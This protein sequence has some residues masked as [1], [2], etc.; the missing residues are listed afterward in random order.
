MSFTSFSQIKIFQID[1][2]E[3]PHYLVPNFGTSSIDINIYKLFFNEKVL[4]KIINI[5]FSK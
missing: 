3:T 4:F 1:I 5:L 2:L